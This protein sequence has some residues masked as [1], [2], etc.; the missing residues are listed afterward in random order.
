MR[1][2]AVD[3]EGAQITVPALSVDVV[4]PVGAGD[5]FAAGFLHG[6]AHD[7]DMRTC[8][9]R[10]HAGAAATLTVRADFATLPPEAMTALLS[11]DDDTWSAAY[12]GPAGI[13]GRRGVPTPHESGT[14]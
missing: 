9:R 12:V 11:C 7:E 1:A 5:S 10:G 4:E 8:L 6:L 14:P 3:R 13:R 2:I